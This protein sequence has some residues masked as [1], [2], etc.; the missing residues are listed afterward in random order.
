[1]SEQ[2]LLKKE[3]KTIKHELCDYQS[4]YHVIMKNSFCYIYATIIRH[5]WLNHFLFEFIS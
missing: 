5:I 4:M 2:L 1:M 3:T